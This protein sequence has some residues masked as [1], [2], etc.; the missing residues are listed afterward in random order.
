VF[1]A[2]FDRPRDWVDIEAMVEARAIDLD[3]AIRW[4]GEM[5]GVDSANARRLARL[6][7]GASPGGG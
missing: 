6:H 1:K 7:P 2:M 5:A 4:V 3:E